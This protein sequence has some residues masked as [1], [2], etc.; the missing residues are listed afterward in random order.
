MQAHGAEAAGRHA[1]FTPGEDVTSFGVDI[2]TAY[3]PAAGLIQWRRDYTL[4]RSAG[5]IRIQD[6][7]RFKGAGNRYEQRFMTACPPR[8][9]DGGIELQVSPERS[10]VLQTTPAPSRVTL[11][12]FEVKDSHVR[13]AWRTRLYQVRLCYEG[14]KSQGRCDIVLVARHGVPKAMAASDVPFEIEE[15]P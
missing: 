10:L 6:E 13:V 1:R 12:E 2:S 4:V 8:L 9:V 3:P 11:H 15:L 14:V 5:T 7:F